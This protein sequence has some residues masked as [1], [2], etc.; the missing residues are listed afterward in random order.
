MS[1]EIEERNLTRL[2]ASGLAICMAVYHL[3]STQ[4]V[5]LSHMQY[6]NVHLAFGLGVVFLQAAEQGRT[7]RRLYLLAFA[8][9]L[10]AVGYIHIEADVL[11]D[12]EGIPSTADT[13][14]GA[15]IIALVILGSYK[16]FGLVFPVLGPIPA[17]KRGP[18]R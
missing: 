6:L 7:A 8:L 14:I 11:A 10:V 1:M 2:A 4:M 16:A 17:W 3:F 13:A 9:S 12:R 15:L 18:G 5:L